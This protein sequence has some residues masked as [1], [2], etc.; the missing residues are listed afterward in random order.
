MAARRR[1]TLGEAD[2]L[3]ANARD[4]HVHVY[5]SRYPAAPGATLLPSDPSRWTSWEGG[6]ADVAANSR[7]M[8]VRTPWLS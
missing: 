1:N 8:A 6:G 4:S 5:D 2:P 3:V 7:G